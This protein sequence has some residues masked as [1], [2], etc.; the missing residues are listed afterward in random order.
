MRGIKN[1]TC[2]KYMSRLFLAVICALFVV[3]IQSSDARAVIDSSAGNSLRKNSSILFL[4]PMSQEVEP[5]LKAQVVEKSHLLYP[6]LTIYKGKLDHHNISVGMLGIGKVNAAYAITQYILATKPDVIILFGSAGGLHALKR[7][8]LFAASQTWTSDYGAQDPSGFVRWEPGVL[9]IGTIQP[10]VKKPVDANIRNAVSSGYPKVEWVSIAT[11]DSFVNNTLL[12]QQLAREGADLVDMESA[13]VA[14][15][16]ARF[17]IPLLIL[18]V[19][20]DGADDSANKSFTESLDQ[21]CENAIPEILSIIRTV[22]DDI[23]AA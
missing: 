8:V 3:S 11:G 12:G 14:D 17:N 5:L 20:S 2:N 23:P 15:L 1:I 7:G 21:V 13:V 18:R 6:D 4:T 10:P 19:V 22:A 16:A 9:P